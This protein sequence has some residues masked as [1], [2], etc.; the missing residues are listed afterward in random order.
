MTKKEIKAAI[1][2]TLARIKTARG[3]ELFR[4]EEELATLEF[5]YMRR[6]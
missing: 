2:D 4:L 6:T 1:K 5:L 3:T